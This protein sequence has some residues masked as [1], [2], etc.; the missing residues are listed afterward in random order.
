MPAYPMV[1]AVVRHG[2]LFAV[3]MAGAAVA[4]G[5]YFALVHASIV[6]A[7]IGVAA[8][9]MLYVLLKSYVELVTII[10]DMMLPK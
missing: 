4:L 1:N 10:A 9:G 3:V 7:L 5:V 8:G 6:Y 2:N